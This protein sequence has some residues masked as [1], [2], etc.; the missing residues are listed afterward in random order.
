MVE[1]NLDI[2]SLDR[3]PLGRVLVQGFNQ[4][5]G[6]PG[7]P[8]L[9]ARGSFIVV[10]G[11]GVFLGVRGGYFSNNPDPSAPTHLTSVAEDPSLRMSFCGGTN[12][13]YRYLLP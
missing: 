8:S 9:A 6:A 4:G 1:W 10:G 3:T 13:V 2:Q 7:A 5:P 11:T 12:H